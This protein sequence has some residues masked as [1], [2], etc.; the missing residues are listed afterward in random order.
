MIRWSVGGVVG[1]VGGCC[2]SRP[3]RRR[4][5]PG[6]GRSSA[7][8]RA[9]CSGPARARRGRGPG[10]PVP[11]GSVPRGRGA[12]R[13]VPGV[14]ESGG[15]VPPRLPGTPLPAAARRSGAPVR[16]PGDRLGA[17][18]PRLGCRPIPLRRRRPGRAR[19]PVPGGHRPGG[20]PGVRRPAGPRAAGPAP[21]ARPAP[22]DRTRRT[23][24]PCRGRR[25][26]AAGARGGPAGGG[27][28][29]GAVRAPAAGG[30][31]R[32]GCAA[33]CCRRGSP[34]PLRRLGRTPADG[35]S[36]ACADGHRRMRCSAGAVAPLSGTTAPSTVCVVHRYSDRA[37]SRAVRVRS[38]GRLSPEGS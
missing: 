2:G 22:R 25:A 18:S 8:H 11:G 4:R 17:S 15:P 28:A 32:P 10:G 1:W 31:R 38:A 16:A 12:S 9:R 7:R 14:P 27:G 3:G 35:A 29:G 24:C 21:A 26:R 33:P 13:S 6:R 23:A 20:G 37:D 5:D 30:R 36:P 19:R 34:R